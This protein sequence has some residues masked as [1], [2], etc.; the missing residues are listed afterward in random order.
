MCHPSSILAL[1]NTTASF[2]LIFFAPYSHLTGVSIC[3]EAP[4]MTNKAATIARKN[5][6]F[7]LSS[8]FAFRTL[9]YYRTPI[10][11]GGLIR[12]KLPQPVFPKRATKI[13][14]FCANNE[15]F[16]KRGPNGGVPGLAYAT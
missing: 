10:R 2:S 15:C 5:T 14:N 13:R 11:H 1:K 6:F 8:F 16:A 12:G 9:L 3:A 4:F 7:I